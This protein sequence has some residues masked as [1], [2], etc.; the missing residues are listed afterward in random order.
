MS[1]GLVPFP[2]GALDGSSRSSVPFLM[3]YLQLG[4]WNQAMGI[5]FH[6]PY[7]QNGSDS[8]ST[9]QINSEE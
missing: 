8:K 2:G 3:I 4:V 9:L 1:S 7:M 6:F 5:E